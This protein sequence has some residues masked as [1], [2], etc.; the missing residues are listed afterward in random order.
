MAVHRAADVEEEQQLDGVVALGAG[1]DVEPALLGG[2]ADGG[3]KVEL[4]GGA[5]ARPA[6]QAAQRHLDRAGAELDVVVEVAELAAV[7]DLD[8]AAVAALV[9]A[10][11]DALGVVAEG[12][13]RRGAGGA[14]PLRAALVPALLL[15]QAVGERLHQLVE[16]AHRLDLRLLLRGQVLL[17]ELLQPVVGQVERSA[18]SATVSPRGRRRPAANTRS[19]RST[20][21]SSFT[22]LAR[23]RK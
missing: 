18:I 22:R 3:G 4:V 5:L 19:K 1:D 2:A 17:D 9:L 7:P 20:W 11:A 8:R 14:D 13:E 23:A 10:D 16:A 6:A 21:R 15:A 12:A